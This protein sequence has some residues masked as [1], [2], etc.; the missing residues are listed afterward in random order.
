[1]YNVTY[2]TQVPASAGY[3][4]SSYTAGYMG[5]F[6]AGAAV[7]AIIAS[8]TGYYYPPYA[9]HGYYYPY[10][11]TYGYHTYNSYTGAYGYGGAA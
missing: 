2:V 9:Y 6:V 7:G 10:A 3:V 4:T 8:G 11:A 1:V 5:M